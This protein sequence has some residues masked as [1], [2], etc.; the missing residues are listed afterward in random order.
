M[1]RREAVLLSPYRPP[2][3]YPV[4]LNPDEAEA[5]LRG[6]FALWHP[7]TLAI[8][9]RPPG[10]AASYDHDIPRDGFLYAVPEGPTIYQV[11][12]WDD[13]VVASG[14]AAFRPTAEGEV[15]AS[16]WKEA[17]SALNLRHPLRAAPEAL[18]DAPA[19]IV[20]W[21]EAIGL[22][23]V[24]VDT[25]FDAASHDRMLDEPAFW[26][27]IS[28]AVNAASSGDRTATKAALTEAGKKLKDALAVLNSNAVQFVDIAIVTD[29]T[30]LTAWPG[31]LAAGL[32]LSIISS[33]EVLEELGRTQ[34]ERFAELKA[35]F[36]PELPSA[37]DLCIGSY[38][39]RDDADRTP[40][41]QWWNLREARRSVKALFG[42]EPTVYARTTASFHP[43]LPSWLL[44][45]GYT[46]AVLLPFDASVMPGRNTVVVNWTAP[47]GRGLEAFARVPLDASD[48]LSFFNLASTIHKAFQ[49]DSNPTVAFKHG[50]HSAGLGYDQLIAL[51]ELGD[52]LGTWISLAGLLKATQYGDYLGLQS[53]D[54]FFNDSLDR[55]V[56]AKHATP[57][58]EF[59]AVLRRRREVDAAYA[60]L[61][62]HRSLTPGSTPEAA[63][64]EEVEAEE[65]AV[66]LSGASE[67]NLPAAAALLAER[68]QVRSE[69]NHPGAM[70]FNPCNFTRRVA[71]ELD[72]F[73]GLVPIADPVKASEIDGTTSRVVVEVPSLGFAWIPRGSSTSAPSKARLKTAEGTIVRNEFLEAELDAATGALRSARDLRSRTNRFGLQLAFH[74]GSRMVARRAGATKSGAALGEVTSEGDIVGEHNEP[75]CRF[76]LRLRA[77]VGRPVLE[78]KI[79]LEPIRPA[80]GYAWHAYYGARFAWR[81]ARA[82]LFRGCQGSTERTTH[83]RPSSLD[84]LE[85][86]LGPE[87]TFLYTG[88]LPFLQKFEDRMV[89]VVLLPEGETARSF[90]LL[91]AFDRE[92]PMQTA[93]GWVTPSPVVRTDKGAPHIGRTGW[94]AHVDLPSLVMTSLKPAP[95][96][97]GAD[98]AV[99]MRLMETTGFA[100]AA[101]LRFAR[102]PVRASL[103]RNDGTPTGDLT[104]NGGAIPVELSASEAAC[105]KAEW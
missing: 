83:A 65:R 48:P 53:A 34:P 79:E 19:E 66:E 42:I 56:L 3:S 22:A 28:A 103:V 43:H 27:D 87:R 39:E 90:E 85:A 96:S 58:S 63:L 67:S 25:L 12:G 94:L 40:E 50:R 68:I 98:R 62:L 74:P 89:D 76:E 37:V 55:R 2:T 24:L 54:D 100:G 91:V 49:G 47:D 72:D 9:D 77:W 99:A 7:A 97:E 38:R 8:V 71:L 30:E 33:G 51:C 92:V 31:S 105:I 86:R 81:D 35:K 57:V 5:W 45:A 14:A 75:L 82:A 59:A 73:G 6:Y 15:T 70:V 41:S 16:R 102:D 52:P 26:V 21:F 17:I 78:I 13:R 64:L 101:D 36:L 69:P 4:S 61:A 23:F 46:G 29:P 11:E 84:F 32:P 10:C 60:L 88:G 44:H 104:V 20:R 95:A 18:I 80:V 93:L 1:T